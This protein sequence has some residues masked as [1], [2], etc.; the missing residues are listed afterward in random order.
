MHQFFALKLLLTK[1]SFNIVIFM[2][3]VSLYC[4]SNFRFIAKTKFADITKVSILKYYILFL[5]VCESYAIKCE[6]QKQ[7]CNQL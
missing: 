5:H 1:N 7:S 3:N 4:G 6:H 2:S